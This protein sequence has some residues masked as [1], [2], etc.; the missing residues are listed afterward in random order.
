MNA[1]PVASAQSVAT[2]ANTGTNLVL[3]ATDIDGPSL[4]YSILTNPS[5]GTLS[6]LSVNTGAVTYTPA[7]NYSGTDGFTFTASDGLLASTGTVSIAVTPPPDAYTQWAIGYGIL[8]AKTSDYDGDG[9]PNLLEY[10]LGGNPSDRADRGHAP[11]LGVVTLNGSNWMEF[12]HVKR[13]APNSG[14][15]YTVQSSD[16]L[17][18]WTSAAAH[19]VGSSPLDSEFDT[20]TYR[21]PIG[22]AKR[23]F[24]RLLIE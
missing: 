13:S 19:M 15:T 6:A 17:A 12:T 8:G 24:I 18:T 7:T 5:H 11:T 2:P 1:A 10:A 23:L 21:F 20:V 14:I 9:A 16:D 3:S 4:T 22:P